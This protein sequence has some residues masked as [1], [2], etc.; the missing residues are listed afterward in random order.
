SAVIKQ[1]INAAHGLP[2][3]MQPRVRRIRCDHPGHGAASRAASTGRSSVLGAG[4][5]AGLLELL[6]HRG[7]A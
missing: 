4:R 2:A 6:D 7:V 5:V 1:S 3:T